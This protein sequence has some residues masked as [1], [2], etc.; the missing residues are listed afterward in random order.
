MLDIKFYAHPDKPGVALVQAVLVADL[1]GI[2][3]EAMP[4]LVDS[5][6][7]QGFCTRYAGEF[8]LSADQGLLMTRLGLQVFIGHVQPAY[9]DTA[10]A[11]CGLMTALMA[12]ESERGGEV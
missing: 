2:D 4:L 8:V 10:R 1:A 7:G 12:H 11:V 9:P 5:L 3:G 6:V